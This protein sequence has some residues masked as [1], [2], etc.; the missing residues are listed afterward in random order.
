MVTI[1]GTLPPFDL[2]Q[3]ST[4]EDAVALLARQGREAWILGGG[5]DTLEPLT[6]RIKRPSVVVDLGGIAE[7]RGIRETP[8]GVHIGATTTLTAIAGDPLIRE[9]FALLAE[10][11]DAVGSPQIRNQATIGGNV[12]QMPRCWYFRGGWNC[13]RAG[14]NTCYADTPTAVNREHAIFNLDRCV[15]V[16]PSDVAPALVALDASMAIRSARGERIVPAEDYF[17][18]PSTDVTRTTVLGPGDLL[19]SIRIPPRWAGARFYFEKVRDRKV[20]DFALASIASTMRLASGT[21]RDVRLVLNGVAARPMRLHIIEDAVR[22]RLRDE[23]TASS[24]ADLAIEG[25]R[26]LRHNAYKVALAR[27]LVR[28]A[29]RGGGETWTS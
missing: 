6:D 13:Y 29:I 20:W 22:G 15:A 10:A 25:A 7:L 3:P 4:L 19:T 9:R 17:I 2:F 28:R 27:N 24:A 12:T 16:N 5:L 26:P 14:G 21:I 18:G 1:R 11:A 8:A 23:Q